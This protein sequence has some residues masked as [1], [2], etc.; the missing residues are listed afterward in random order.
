MYNNIFIIYNDDAVIP[1]VN[2]SEDFQMNFVAVTLEWVA[3]N[4]VSHVVYVTPERAINY[5]GKSSAQLSL[6]YNIEYNVSVVASLCGTAQAV[7]SVIN[8][9]KLQRFIRQLICEYIT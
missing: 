7:S 4:G 2:V 3:N 9:S 6:S 1:S 8:Y 5:T